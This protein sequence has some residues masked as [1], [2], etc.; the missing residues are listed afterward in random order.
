MGEKFIISSSGVSRA[1][2]TMPCRADG[3]CMIIPKIPK[4]S[5]GSYISERPLLRGLVLEGLIFGGAYLRR[6]ICRFKI[7][8]QF[9]IFALFYYV[10]GG[11]FQA[12]LE[13]R[14]NG[15]FFVLRVWGG[16]HIWR[17]LYVEGIIFGIL[18]YYSRLLTTPAFKGNRK[19]FKLLTVQS[20]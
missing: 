18:W 2:D 1:F 4:I 6:E 14:F 10:F 3:W 11:N 19:M 8:M 12:H 13:R 16:A 17:G 20:K 7:E 5:S 9:T 15:G